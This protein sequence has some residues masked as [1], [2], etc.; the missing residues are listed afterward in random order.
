MLDGGN[1]EPVVSDD[2]G[3]AGIYH[4]IK[5]GGERW[6]FRKVG[7]N[8]FDT[9]VKGCGFY[10][11]GCRFSRMHADSGAGDFFGNRTLMKIEA[12]NR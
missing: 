8:E 1:D 3:K 12:H 5:M 7:S 4:H 6:A 9:V 10:S 11:K 2:R